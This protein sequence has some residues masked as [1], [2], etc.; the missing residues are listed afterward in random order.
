VI[1]FPHHAGL[2]EL[3]KTF[4]LS[5]RKAKHYMNWAYFQQLEN[6]SSDTELGLGQKYY[7]RALKVSRDLFDEN[8]PELFALYNAIGT[9]ALSRS[10]SKKRIVTTGALWGSLERRSSRGNP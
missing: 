10:T 5:K 8:D 3:L 4:L 9:A 7:E 2:E 1:L 6:K